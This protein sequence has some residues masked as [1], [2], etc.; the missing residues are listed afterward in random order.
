[1]T[2]RWYRSLYWRIAIGFVLSLAAMLIGQ[3]M[4][5]VWVLSRS[6]P[7]LPGEP[8]RFAQ[9]VAIDLGQ[10]LESE[11]EL[12]VTGYISDQY[13]RDAHPFFVMLADERVFGNTSGPI[14]EG[15][16]RAA[17]G[18]LQRGESDP[19]DRRGRWRFGRSTP[20]DPPFAPAPL[21][22]PPVPPR[23]R[24]IAAATGGRL[25]VQRDV[26]RPGG[27]R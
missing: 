12:D 14:P 22:P 15:L 16:M 25:G 27:V 7:R 21:P 20:G 10:A 3:A 18:R 19:F 4:L 6:G 2:R 5:F 8:E 24:R 26:R 9:T 1:V 17:R 13:A 11:P 23:A